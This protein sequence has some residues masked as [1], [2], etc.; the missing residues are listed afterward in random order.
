MFEFVYGFE[1]WDL[2]GLKLIKR[3]ITIEYNNLEKMYTLR[4]IFTWEFRYI[5]VCVRF[6]HSKNT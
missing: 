1:H 4:Y 5:G 3:T 2:F 6:E